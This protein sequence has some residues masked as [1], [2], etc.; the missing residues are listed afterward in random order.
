MRYLEQMGTHNF[1]G[2]MLVLFESKYARNPWF[3]QSM[4]HNGITLP[5]YYSPPTRNYKWDPSLATAA[6]PKGMLF[7][8]VVS[9][10]ELERISVDQARQF[11]SQM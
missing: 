11:R 10:G 9:T 8:V 7:L 4:T 3:N 2:S 1:N 5:N 6:P